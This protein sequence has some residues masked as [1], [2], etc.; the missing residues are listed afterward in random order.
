MIYFIS[1]IVHLDVVPV[2]VYVLISV[3]KNR[4]GARIS[5]ITCHVIRNHQYYLTVRY[6]ET[7]HASVDRQY[8]GYMTIIEPKAARIYENGPVICVTIFG[9]FKIQLQFLV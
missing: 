3:I 9:K 8:V 2:H 6:S 1:S 4:R 7:L 5:W